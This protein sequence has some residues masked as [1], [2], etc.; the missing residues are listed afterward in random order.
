MRSLLAERA[1]R[2]MQRHAHDPGTLANCW[3]LYQAAGFMKRLRGSS[4]GTYK[5]AMHYALAMLPAHPTR[6]DVEAWLNDM[7][8]R[9]KAASTVNCYYRAVLAIV[10][11]AQWQSQACWDT[12]AAFSQVTQLDQLPR[13]RRCPP[14]DAAFRAWKALKH[15]GE[16]AFVLIIASGPRV[17]EM[18]ALRPSDIEHEHKP[19]PRLY[20]ARQRHGPRKNGAPYH[21]KL[22][23][24]QYRELCW[25]VEHPEEM[26]SRSGW[27]QGKSIGYIFPWGMTRVARMM[28]DIR[29]ALGVADAETYFKPGETAWHAF[30]HL[31]GTVTSQLGGGDPVRIQQQ[32]GDS[33]IAQAMTYCGPVRGAKVADGRQIERELLN[34]GR[35]AE[36]VAARP[37][38]TDPAAPPRGDLAPAARQ[39]QLTTTTES[40]SWLEQPKT[41]SEA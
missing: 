4:P 22:G 8:A 19:E 38:A 3:E 33:S 37:A 34:A 7:L 28:R 35:Q 39:G 20:I 14:A 16:Q 36:L 31:A 40:Y 2:V 26:R 30:R 18:L 1:S 5:T 12:A 10:R 41:E 29:H 32:L 13:E 11:V 17:G 23:P 9:R 24:L 27:H 21:L 15:R 25:C 6:G